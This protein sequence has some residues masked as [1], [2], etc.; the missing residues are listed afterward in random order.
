MSSASVYHDDVHTHIGA[1]AAVTTMIYIAL[2]GT[3]WRLLAA[4]MIA[5]KSDT[6]TNLGQAMLFQY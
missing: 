2:I 6:A 5:S 4:H 3:L 1:I